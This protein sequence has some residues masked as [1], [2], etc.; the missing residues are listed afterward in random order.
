MRLLL[1]FLKLLLSAKSARWLVDSLD[2]VAIWVV[3]GLA[4][5]I[6][7][8]ATTVRDDNLTH[9]GCWWKLGA[10]TGGPYVGGCSDGRGVAMRQA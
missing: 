4:A 8:A 1:L 2:L 6:W 10:A 9:V 3:A 7:L 5:H